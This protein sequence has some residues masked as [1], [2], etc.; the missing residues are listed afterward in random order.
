MVVDAIRGHRS[1]VGARVWTPDPLILTAR[2]LASKNFL[3]ALIIFQ[4]TC[5]DNDREIG[6]KSI[7]YLIKQ[8]KDLWD[9]LSALKKME[10]FY[11]RVG[12]GSEAGPVGLCSDLRQDRRPFRIYELVHYNPLIRSS[13][14]ICVTLALDKCCWPSVKEHWKRT[15]GLLSIQ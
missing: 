5:I 9:F 15:E 12:R 2:P 8:K 3:C 14:W 7:A 4:N 13:C 6:K 11:L 1:A 10:T